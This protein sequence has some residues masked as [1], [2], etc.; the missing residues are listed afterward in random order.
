MPIAANR[1]IVPVTDIDA[2][3]P[4]Y[5]ALL[6]VEPHTD[7]PYYVGYSVGGQ[8]VALNPGGA[9]LGLTGTTP[10]WDVPDVGAALA[11]LEAAGATITLPPT[12][13]GGGT[14]LGHAT[15]AD[16]NLVALIGSAG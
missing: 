11:A 10:Y 1:I 5:T 7:T 16:G 8:E 3:K 6:G 13:V 15:D 4:V 14:I 9:Q 2:A 12:E